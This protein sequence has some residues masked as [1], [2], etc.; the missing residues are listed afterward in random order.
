MKSN[1]NYEFIKETRKEK[2]INK[3]KLIIKILITVFLSIL[4]GV[5]ASVCYTVGNHNLEAVLY[6][7]KI[8]T[9]TIAEDMEPIDMTV[10]EVSLPEMSEEDEEEPETEKEPETVINNI[11][12]KVDISTNDY[13]M[14][15]AYLH[16]IAQNASKSVVTVVGVDSDVDWFEN[17]Y[18][19]SQT[20]TGLIIADNGVELLI[21]ADWNSLYMAESIDVE[22]SDGCVLEAEMKMCDEETGLAII[23]I[24]MDLIPQNVKSSIEYASFGNTKAPSTN[25]KAII[26][27]GR[28]LGNVNSVAYGFISSTSRVESLTDSNVGILTTDI[29]GSQDASGVIINLQGKVLGIITNNYSDNDSINLINAYAISD[30]KPLIESLSNGKAR[31][32]MG[33]KGT[34][35]SVSIKKNMGI[36]DGAYVT[37]SIMDS[38]AMRAGIQ[39]GDVITK[40]NNTD[41]L[42]FDDYKYAIGELHPDDICTVKLKR[43]AMG[44]YS[45]LQVDVTL[46]SIE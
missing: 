20:T 29:Y 16:E 7:E 43:Y 11:V 22:F 17:T 25:G 30:L 26:A 2:P 10:S 13:E 36:P 6:P 9:V 41:I 46:G 38:P 4:F 44:Q 14:L 39:S 32:M 42:S 8:E 15:Y 37:E 40:I 3:R 5:V 12:E 23:G 28:P 24:D 31:T 19:N 21:L 1:E 33:I 45:E 35:V 27:I 34:N 18:E